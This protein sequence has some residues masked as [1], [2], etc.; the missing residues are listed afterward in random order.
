MKADKRMRVLAAFVVACLL[1]AVA[2]AQADAAD[3]GPVDAPGAVT[4]AG[5][6]L[7]GRQVIA[8]RVDGQTRTF[9]R[10]VVIRDG[11]PAYAVGEAIV[12]HF[13]GGKPAGVSHMR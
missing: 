5:K 12:V 3:A 7:N 8:F 11:N 9:Y 10:P 2:V 13:R 6:V 1:L 4:Q